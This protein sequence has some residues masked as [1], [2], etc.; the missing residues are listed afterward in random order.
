METAIQTLL[1]WKV[2]ILLAGLGLL[3]VGERLC[4]SARQSRSDGRS[5]R[6]A[7]SDRTQSGRTRLDRTRLGRTRVAI[8]RL[9]SPRVVTNGVLF[10]LNGLV[11]V[12]V[13]VPVSLV[14]A[15]HALDWRPDGWSGWTG[16][17]LDLLILDFAIYWWHRA[18]HKI[19]LLWRFHEIHH[20]DGLLD[21]TSAVRFHFGEVALSA[22]LRA[23]VILL[24][25]IPIES[26]L[27]F[28][29]MVLLMAMFNHSNLR[30]PGWLEQPLSWVIVTPSLHWVHHHAVRA[31]T[32]STYGNT[33]S[34]WD[35][36]FGSRSATRRW[37]DMPIGVEGL[38]PLPLAALLVR[39]FRGGEAGGGRSAPSK[40]A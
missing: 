20:L 8:A 6:Q 38:G 24:C 14:A 16:L 12:V 35:R 17:A 19:P 34:I 21:T 5:G 29:V 32:D 22:C 31:D 25:G 7:Q 1:A 23:G 37:P 40:A 4:P 28:E 26:V 10:G 39:P 3:A 13:V 27:L 36:L 9:I 30:L 11:S 33:L 15:T 18:N 2:V